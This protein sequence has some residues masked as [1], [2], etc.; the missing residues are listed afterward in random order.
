MPWESEAIPLLHSIILNLLALTLMFVA[1]MAASHPDIT[2]GR[3]GRGRKGEPVAFVLFAVRYSS[4]KPP[5]DCLFLTGQ[6]FV[7]QPRSQWQERPGHQT[8]TRWFHWYPAHTPNSIARSE[9]RNV[10]ETVNQVAVGCMLKYIY[11]ENSGFNFLL[12]ALL[13]AFNML[14][15]IEGDTNCPSPPWWGRVVIFRILPK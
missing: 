10:R 4:Q 7:I 9:E 11:L 8:S 13:R 12:I 14:I 2:L 15:H 1:K 6:N 5:K 3:L